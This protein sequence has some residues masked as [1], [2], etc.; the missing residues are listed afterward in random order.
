[1]RVT[2]PQLP[3]I[4]LSMY[5]EAQYAVWLLRMGAS[6][7]LSKGRS[8]AELIEAIRA[9]AQGRR[10]ITRA[11]AD[12]LIDAGAEEGAPQERLSEREHLVHI[13]EKL[14][15][16]TNGELIQYAYRARLTSDSR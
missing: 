6:T 14:D 15:V 12:S 8:S 10:Y 13:R 5:P 4:V 2:C 9:A 11:V 16:R 7:Y 1:M 3:V